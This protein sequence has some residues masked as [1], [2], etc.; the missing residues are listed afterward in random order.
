MFGHRIFST[1]KRILFGM[2]ALALVLAPAQAASS[3]KA[4]VAM[5]GMA[6]AN[7]SKS[8][9]TAMSKMDCRQKKNCCDKEKSGCP[10]PQSCMVQCNASFATLNSVDDQLI[11]FSTIV[12][13]T[14]S[15]LSPDSTVPPPLRR[16]P[17][18]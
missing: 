6:M 16:P 7:M 2:I 12:L 11:L 10:S 14:S 1:L 13:M 4:N 5:T 9:M 15:A 8:K 18:I 17:R 3:P